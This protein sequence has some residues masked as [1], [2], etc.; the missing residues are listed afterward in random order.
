MGVYEVTLRNVYLET[1]KTLFSISDPPHMDHIKKK[2]NQHKLN[3][4]GLWSIY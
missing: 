4:F 2:K 1:W 3:G